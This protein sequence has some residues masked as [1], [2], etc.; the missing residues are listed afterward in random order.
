MFVC[1]ITD[2]MAQVMWFEKLCVCCITD[3]MI[4]VMWFEKLYVS[5]ALQMTWPR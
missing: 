1:C 3:D 5:V 2:D 4:Q